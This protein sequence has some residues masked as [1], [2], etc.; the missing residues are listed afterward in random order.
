MTTQ[1][2]DPNARKKPTNLSLNSDLLRQAKDLRI[3]LSQTLE[4]CLV[5]MLLDEKQR[6]WREKNREAI[7]AYNRRI[8]KQGVFSNDFRGF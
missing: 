4:R 2:Y 7:D 1:L 6:A 5:Q 3:N 8:E